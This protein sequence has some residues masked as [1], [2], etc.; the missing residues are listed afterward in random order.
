MIEDGEVKLLEHNVRF[1][2]PECQCL[3]ARMRGDLVDLLLRAATGTLGD[4]PAMAWSDD[5]AAVVVVA[6]EGYPG[7]YAKGEAIGGLAEA[8]AKAGVKVIHAGT[9]LDA[10]TG[11]VLSAADA[12]WASSGRARPSRRPPPGR[13]PEWTRSSGRAVS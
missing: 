9:A 5:V 3:M 4:A 1:G 12:C 7:A 13:T 8:N 10:K 2:D 11:D 6:A